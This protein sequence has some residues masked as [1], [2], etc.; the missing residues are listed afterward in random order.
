M[1]ATA[2]RSSGSGNQGQVIHRHPSCRDSPEAQHVNLEM[3][4]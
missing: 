3:A 2:G 4:K 1:M